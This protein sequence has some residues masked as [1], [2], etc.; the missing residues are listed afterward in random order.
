MHEETFTD[1]VAEFTVKTEGL[2]R[3]R[4][5]DRIAVIQELLNRDDEITIRIEPAELVKA[6]DQIQKEVVR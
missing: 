5:T 6:T 3:T 4:I 2:M 1:L